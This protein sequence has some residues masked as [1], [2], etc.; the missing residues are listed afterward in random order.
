APHRADIDGLR[1]VAVLGVLAYHF[2]LGVP[3][4]YGGVD[5]FFVISGFLIA[6]IIK[7]ELEAGTFSLADFYVRRIRRILPALAVCLSVTT[8]V[9][10]VILFP[11]DFRSYGQSLTAV[12]IATSNIFFAHKTGN[13]FDASATASPLLHT[14]S[15]SIEEQFYLVFPLAA[16]L[17]FRARRALILPTMMILA[18]LSLA[19]SVHAVARTPGM[20]FFS[21]PGRVWELLFGTILAFAAFS[22]VRNRVV[23][24]AEAFAGIGLIAGCYFAYSAMTPFPGLAA[25]PLCLGAVLFIHSGIEGSRERAPE[26]TAVAR[27]LSTRP[28]VA[29]GKISYSVYLWHWPLL[30]FVQYRFESVMDGA[31][32]HTVLA[33]RSL[34]AAIS[35]GLGALS[36]RFVE[37]PFRKRA[38]AH[39]PWPTFAAGM[40]TFAVVIG[41]SQLVSLRTNW[42]QG[43]SPEVAG[44]AKAERRPDRPS[45][46]GPR[47]PVDQGWPADSYFVGSGSGNVDTLVWGDSHAMA[48][49][50]GLR[51]YLERTGQRIVVAAHSGCPPLINVSFHGNHFEDRCKPAN[52]KVF[53]AI[54][55]PA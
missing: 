21:T 23:R 5:V 17:L 29:I 1:A 49:L 42:L 4:G 31:D 34:L 38:A 33:L 22:S 55:N 52:D 3:G 35:I 20:A 2:G 48:I 40:A 15:L 32:T 37:Q 9:A 41:C 25:V 11:F 18:S 24:E 7:A 10:S 39:G 27:F 13:Y 47:A 19:Y 43:W 54:S 12:S 14:W 8:V 53:A 46:F 36:W 28:A 51:D 6:G 30:V 50:P 45:A 26:A 44:L 16:M